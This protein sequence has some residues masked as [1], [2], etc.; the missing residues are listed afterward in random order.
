MKRLR[1]FTLVE[2]LVVIGIIAILAA[3]LLPALAKAKATAQQAG[4]Y[5]NL[6]Q[7]GVCEQMYI[8]DNRDFP[9]TDGDGDSTGYSGTDPYGS[10]DDPNAWFNQLPPYWS[11]KTYAYYYD[12]RP[13]LNWQTGTPTSKAQDYMPFPGRAGNK[14]W[15][16]PSAQMSDA[17]VDSLKPDGGEGPGFF[18]YA[19]SLDLN[20]I[21]GTSTGAPG[22]LGSEPQGTFI[23]TNGQHYSC[24]DNTEPKVSSLP[25]PAATVYL[26]DEAFNAANEDS[27]RN[28]WMY[29]SL[30]P[31]LRFKSFASRH[32][33]GGVIVFCDGHARYY[34]DSYIT[35]GVT[36]TMWSQKTESSLSEVIWD[37]AYRAALGH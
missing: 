28:D 3:M 1:G 18:A 9:P 16:C 8:G 14:M 37:A 11:G 17:D 25:K 26:F 4:C 7:W 21:I 23:G 2:L 22:S 12:Q 34:K 29:N 32:T 36:S 35:N 31:G 30:M 27:G 15:F 33:K 13:H 6:K 10:P 19:Q 5:S 24:V 20:K